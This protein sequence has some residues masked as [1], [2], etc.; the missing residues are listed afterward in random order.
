MFRFVFGTIASYDDL[1]LGIDF[2]HQLA[3]LIEK[4]HKWLAMEYGVTDSFKLVLGTDAYAREYIRLCVG[5]NEERI[6]FSSFFDNGYSFSEALLQHEKNRRDTVY[7]IVHDPCVSRWTLVDTRDGKTSLQLWHLNEFALEYSNH[8]QASDW[9]SF[10]VT[11][12][13]LKI[14]DAYRFLLRQILTEHHAKD[15]EKAILVELVIKEL[16]KVDRLAGR[17]NEQRS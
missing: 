17:I 16:Q 7:D 13:F 14:V 11:T 2:C 1:L 6:E 5:V 8:E 12:S 4:I 10:E 3:F 9:Q 15:T